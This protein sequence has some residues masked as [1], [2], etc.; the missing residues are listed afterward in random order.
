MKPKPLIAPILG[1]LWSFRPKWASGLLPEILRHALQIDAYPTRSHK[2]ELQPLSTPR[3]E[4]PATATVSAV[5]IGEYCFPQLSFKRGGGMLQCRQPAP[6]VW[7]PNRHSMLSYAFHSFLVGYV[8][9]CLH[10]DDFASTGW[11]N[12]T[13][14]C[15]WTTKTRNRLQSE[16][17]PVISCM[18]I[19]SLRAVRHRNA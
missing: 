14:K 2:L 13:R 1:T 18:S 6:S 11:P 8:L 15:S 16:D 4:M 19:Q 9:H 3:N 5:S 12:E 10:S 7:I 17:R